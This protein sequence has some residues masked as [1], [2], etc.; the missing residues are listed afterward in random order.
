MLRKN[1]SNIK[2]QQGVTLLE[3]AGVLGIFGLFMA[4][5]AWSTGSLM[6]DTKVSKDSEA[7]VFIKNKWL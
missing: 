2:K 1:F 3:L 4:G 6:D 7:L 5:I